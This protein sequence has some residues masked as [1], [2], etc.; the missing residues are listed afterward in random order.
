MTDPASPDKES[1]QGVRFSGVNKEIEPDVNLEPTATGP[2]SSA[3]S[4]VPPKVQQEL[5]DLSI[6]MQKCQLQAKRMQNFAYEPM[7]LP[8]SR[9]RIPKLFNSHHNSQAERTFHGEARTR[10]AL[11]CR[12]H[13]MPFYKKPA[14]ASALSCVCF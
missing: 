14:V 3:R 8:T 11:M 10:S 5:R 1:H 7:S 12:T 9:V 13:A 6:S 2:D 4:E